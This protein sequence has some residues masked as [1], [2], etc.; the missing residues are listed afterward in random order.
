MT[1]P[2]Q[3][4]M[5]LSVTRPSD[6]TIAFVRIVGDVDLSDTDA[7][8]LAARQLLAVPAS[9]TYVDLGG[10]SL[11]GSTLV[12]FLLHLADARGAIRRP[13]VLCR[14]TLLGRKVIRITGLDQVAEIWPDL[15]SDWPLAVPV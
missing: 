9:V 12:A 15:P 3:E 5:L 13:L 6:S 11:V 4:H 10:A 7:L 1:L 2:T 8:D 14:P